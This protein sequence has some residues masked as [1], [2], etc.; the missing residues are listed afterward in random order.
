MSHAILWINIQIDGELLPSVF[1]PVNSIY[2]GLQQICLNY[3]K[4][5]QPWTKLL[6]CW[7]YLSNF[8]TLPGHSTNQPFPSQQA[9]CT[10]VSFH[11]H[12]ENAVSGF[13]C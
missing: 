4:N 9:I 13:C 11:Y 7:A 5:L 1:F 3:A 12:N 8:N 2:E 6:R 10:M